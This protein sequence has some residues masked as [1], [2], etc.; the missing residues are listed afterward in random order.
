MGPAARGVWAALALLQARTGGAS[1]AEPTKVEQMKGA[2]F[3]SVIADALALG[4]HYEYDAKKIRDFYGRIDR[5]YA[6]GE[7]TGGKTHGIGWGNRDYH[8]GNGVGPAKKA[9]E[10]TDYGDYAILML[11]HLAATSA[12]PHRVALKELVPRW[13]EALKTWRSWICSQTRQTAQQLSQGTP[14]NKLGGMSNAMSLRSAAS[15][16]YYDKEEDVVHAAKTMMFTHRERTALEGGEFFARVAF[17]IIHKGLDPQAAIEEVAAES[18]SFIKSK[19]KQ[20][21]DKV[22]EATDPARPLSKEEFADDLALTSMARLW[23]VGKTEPIKVGKA[24]PTEGTLP[25]SVYLIVKY[26]DFMGAAQAN[27]EIGGDSA[28]RS[29]AIGMVLG[30]WKGLEGIPEKLRK[31]FVDYDRLDKLLDKLPL[32]QGIKKKGPSGG[33]EL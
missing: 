15:F 24:S 11:E 13:Q 18:S 33:E 16:G 31:D 17:R 3:G 32:V 27:A 20:A 12:K 30:A 25:G 19:V 23:D 7:K 29:V 9:G 10:C 6:P 1:A 22:K 2:F 21:L 28:S 4:T 26:K 8:G 5:F 14:L